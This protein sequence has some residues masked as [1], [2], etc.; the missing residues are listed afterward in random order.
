MAAGRLTDRLRQLMGGSAVAEPAVPAGAPPTVFPADDAASALLLRTASAEGWRVAIAGAGT[1][2]PTPPTADVLLST[3]RLTRV[4]PVDA[5]DLIATAQAGVR[6]SALRRELADHGMWLAQDA[7]GA[8]RSLGS[9]LATATAG[10]LRAGFG[11]ARDHVLGLTLATGD[12]R[13]V[14]VGGRVVKNVAGYDV[15][16][17]ALG[18]FGA[19]G[20]ITSVH[21]RL[22]AVPRA[23]VTLALRG[24]RD[25]LLDAAE[26]VLADGLMPAALELLSPRAAE[27]DGWTLAIRL[28]GTEAEVTADRELV[29]AAVRRPLA[30]HGGAAAAAFWSNVHAGSL[31]GSVTLRLGAETTELARALD[32]V[33]LHLDERVADWIAV[34]V[35][36]G[37]VRWSGTVDAAPLVRLRNAAAGMEWPMTLERAPWPIR[38]RAGH[39]GAYREGVARL[40]RGLRAAFD[41][42][43]VLVAPIDPA[44]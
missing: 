4:G 32:L 39:F 10:P 26:S 18:S 3:A 15:A 28:L 43:G 41:P 12:G 40:V 30:V 8:D 19:F 16:K 36:A 7:P 13:L 37:T 24:T 2:M 38:E 25:T 23:D 21:L 29:Q 5:A 35:T 6:W 17:L 20:V 9:V 44:P 42:A 22:R 11:G 34:T 27:S 1:W 33:A 14:R 31:H